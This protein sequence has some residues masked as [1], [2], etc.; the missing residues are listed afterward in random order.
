MRHRTIPLSWPAVS[1]TLEPSVGRLIE[2]RVFDLHTR[3]EADE[4]SR[5]LAEVVSQMP[6]GVA[7]VLCADH[8]PVRIYPQPAA[9]RL[10]ELFTHMN[11]RLERVAILV[12][13]TNATLGLQLDRIVL[14]A[15]KDSEMW[16]YVPYQE[17]AQA[18]RQDWSWA[19][20]PI[21]AALEAELGSMDRNTVTVLADPALLGTLGLMHWLSGFYERARGGRFG[22]I[23]LALPGGVHDNRV[24]LNERYNLPYTPDMAAVYLDE[25]A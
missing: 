23:V 11:S 10:A 4:Y 22:L 16:A 9:D 3:E 19:H 18:G 21:E 1:Y 8:R 20:A 24:R 7:P 14:Q 6:K 25:V 2:A 12:S 17:Q 5:R 15:L 13:P